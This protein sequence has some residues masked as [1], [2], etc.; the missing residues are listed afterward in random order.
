MVGARTIELPPDL[1]DLIRK[2]GGYA[3]ITPQGWA[4]YYTDLARWQ[5]AHRWPAGAVKDQQP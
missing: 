1:D 2:F 3:T 4:E 5:A